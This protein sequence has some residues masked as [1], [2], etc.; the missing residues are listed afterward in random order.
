MDKIVIKLVGTNGK[1]GRKKY[2]KTIYPFYILV[3]FFF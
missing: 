1:N 2:V 3:F